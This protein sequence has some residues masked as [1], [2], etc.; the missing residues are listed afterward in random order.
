MKKANRP[1]QF[2]T[3][4]YLTRI[5]NQRAMSASELREGL[6]QCSD[7]SIF[8]HTFQ[9]LGRHHF[10]TEGFSNDFAQWVLAA[11]NR[12]KLAEQ[13]AGLDVRSYLSLSDLR[14][15]L[16][17]IMDDFCNTHPDD[18]RRA[19]FEPFHFCASI[20]LTVP[21]AEEAWTLD[22]FRHGLEQLGHGSF[23]FHF[24]VS[25]LRLRLQTNDFS[26]WFANELGLETLALLANRIDI[27]TN[28]IEDAKARLVTLIDRELAA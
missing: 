11:L 26:L 5:D 27:S 18:V 21:L 2:V 9:S 7:A 12:P 19:A 20:E 15:D 24:L 17:R 16:L 23:Q 28:T 6:E 8:Y 25:R 22:E 4:S 13:L 14:S 3:A 10:L 1:F